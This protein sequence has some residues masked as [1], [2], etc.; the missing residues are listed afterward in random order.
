MED[1]TISSNTVQY[2][3]LLSGILELD[4][5]S[6]QANYTRYSFNVL[7]RMQQYVTADAS[8]VLCSISDGSPYEPSTT[9]PAIV[10]DANNQTY[11]C[12][13]QTNGSIR[14]KYLTLVYNNSIPIDLSSIVIRIA[15][16]DMSSI[17]YCTSPNITIDNGGGNSKKA[18]KAYI[19][20]NDIAVIPASIIPYIRY[21][22]NE[23]NNYYSCGSADFN[24]LG[25]SVN[26]DRVGLANL[27]LWFKAGNVYLPLSNNSIP[28]LFVEQKPLQTLSPFA[29]LIG[30]NRTVTFQF[31]SPVYDY[32]PS[33]S[34]Y[35]CAWYQPKYFLRK[36]L[37]IS[38]PAIRL[39]STTFACNI[40]SPTVQT[41]YEV[42]LVAYIPVTDSMIIMQ[43]SPSAFSYWE[44]SNVLSLSPHVANYTYTSVPQSWTVQVNIS[45]LLL[46]NVGLSCRYYSIDGTREVNVSSINGSIATFVI[47]RP[48]LPGNTDLIDLELRVQDTP[49]SSFTLSL[50]NGTFVLLQDQLGLQDT[51]LSPALLGMNNSLTFKAP[52]A[53]ARQQFK[54]I[55]TPQFDPLMAPFV[56]NC[57]YPSGQVAFCSLGSQLLLKYVPQML[58]LRLEVSLI[59]YPSRVATFYM[60]PVLYKEDV[61]ILREYPFIA[62]VSN[63]N[64]NTAL[65]VQFKVNRELNPYFAFNCEGMRV[66]IIINI[67]LSEQN[68]A[69]ES[70]YHSLCVSVGLS[71]FLL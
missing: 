49:T 62:E 50:N 12:F 1:K 59:D 24:V 16:I 7:L 64:N 40:T 65:D 9:F 38:S 43:S 22:L 48:T 67:R 13:M 3:S 58:A 57:T 4:P 39:D 20:L 33:Y 5:S 71:Q 26:Q 42:V 29:S 70:L 25:C 17:S 11:Y 61:N 60:P 45:K 2:T 23:E 69:I 21:R 51:I 14:T 35:R 66:M 36:S 15:W 56:L 31:S 47:S 53:R 30:I 6:P 55:A 68:R 37:R 10:N 63:Y 28:I 54:I 8:R 44:T 41:H 19:T 32:D 52:D 27:T 34:V 18:F 46:T